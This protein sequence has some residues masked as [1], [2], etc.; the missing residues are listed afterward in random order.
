MNGYE[1]IGETADVL[2]YESL[3]G[4]HEIWK[5]KSKCRTEAI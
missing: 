5:K 1:L 2:I 4:T 3:D